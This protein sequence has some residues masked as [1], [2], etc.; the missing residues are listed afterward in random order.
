MNLIL[1]YHD[2]KTFDDDFM[3]LLT[4][5]SHDLERVPNELLEFL[6]CP[7]LSTFSYSCMYLSYALYTPNSE[8]ATYAPGPGVP[9]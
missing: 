4:L 7:F 9:I 1:L 5:R 6:D 3:L 8:G 2:T